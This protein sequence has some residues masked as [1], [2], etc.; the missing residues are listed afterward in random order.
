MM[1]ASILKK[2]IIFT[3]FAL[4]AAL[5]VLDADA[6]SKKAG[7]RSDYSKEQQAEFF[8]EALKACRKHFSSELVGV[9]VDYQRKRFVC[10]GY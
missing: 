10:R 5:P 8:A 1:G 7:S 3:A 4:L 9:K 2:L 6:A